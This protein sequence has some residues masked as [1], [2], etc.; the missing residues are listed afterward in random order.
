MESSP[1]PR[2][3]AMQTLCE[4][5]GQINTELEASVSALE[6]HKA[7]VIEAIASQYESELR[8]HR[9]LAALYTIELERIKALLEQGRGVKLD[10]QCLR[11][12]PT[13]LHFRT[14]RNDAILRKEIV[15]QIFRNPFT[16]EDYF[17]LLLQGKASDQVTKQITKAENSL[18]R[19]SLAKVKKAM[20]ICEILSKCPAFHWSGEISEF[21]L[22]PKLYSR[23]Q[24]IEDCSVELSNTTAN[25]D[26]YASHS[27]SS[28]SLARLK[29][30]SSD[31]VSICRATLQ[32]TRPFSTS[33]HTARLLW[34]LGTSI[35]SSRR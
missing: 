32:R 21:L 22:T 20:W 16:P 11:A 29:L 23:I 34:T 8:K 1:D 6:A 26:C 19:H 25:K 2:T 10:W 3:V 17:S 5:Q 33:I 14:Y 35:I 12:A 18:Q 30:D 31:K 4:L 27:I 28:R 7:W 15:C 24:K 9:Q 13:F